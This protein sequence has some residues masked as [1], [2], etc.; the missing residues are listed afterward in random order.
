MKQFKESTESLYPDVFVIIGVLKPFWD[1][2]WQHQSNNLLQY[3]CSFAARNATKQGFCHKVFMNSFHGEHLWVA[4]SFILSKQLSL[5]KSHKNS[6]N[7]KKL[8][9][10][11][12][13]IDWDKIGVA[14]SSI[15]GADFAIQGKH[16]PSLRRLKTICL[17]P[18]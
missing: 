2:P 15:G 6:P 14:Q 1:Q 7:I 4:T 11:L 3:S 17:T 8:E 10:R 5:V 9:K 12:E 13:I 16:C 18:C